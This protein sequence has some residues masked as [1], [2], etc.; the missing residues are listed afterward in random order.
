MADS[1]DDVITLIVK[2]FLRNP[3]ILEEDGSA[4]FTDEPLGSAIVEEN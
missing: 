4:H 2:P 1:G 3:E